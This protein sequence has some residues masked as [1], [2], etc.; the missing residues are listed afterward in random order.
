[1]ICQI[2]KKEVK[3]V[4]RHVFKSHN[5]LA[6]EYYDKYIANDTDGKCLVCGKKTKFLTINKGYNKYCSTK[7]SANSEV[8]KEN[9][10]KTMLKRYG[11]E[12]PMKSKEIKEKFIKT[13]NEKYGGN[14][15]FCSEKV[16]NKWRKNNIKK[17][18]VD[19]PFKTE[20]VKNKYKKTCLEK[21]GEEFP[22]KYRGK[23][24][25]KNL[26]NKYNDI[27]YNNHSKYEETCMRKYNVTHYSKTKKF[28]DER[29]KSQRDEFYHKIT[30]SDRLKDMVTPLFEIDSYN[31]C[32]ELYKFKCNKCGSIFKDTLKDGKIPRCL[33][34]YPITNGTSN[35]ESELKDYIK[36]IIPNEK[37]IF[38][39]RS[40]LE[41]KELD[42]YI[43]NKS[44]AIELNGNYWHSELS[45]NKS[46][47]YHL[48]K[49][50][51]CENL[52]IQLI[53]IFEDEW[54]F[55]K[56]IVKS[57]LKNIL[58]KNSKTI[59]ARKCN[60]KEINKEEAS[61]FLNG[62]H[63]QG[64]INSKIKLGI[65][66]KESLVSVMTLGKERIALGNKNIIDDNYEILRYATNEMVIGGFGKLLSYFIKNYKPNK[67]ITYA[68][69]RWSNGDIYKLNGFNKISDGVPNYWYMKNHS[70]RIHRF[71]FRKNV[72]N[73][74]LD[75]FDEN[76]TE[77]Q[78]MQLNGYDRIWDCG[79]L[80]YELKIN[81]EKNYGNN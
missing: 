72:L 13:N 76:L 19:V 42:I 79:S 33:V 80:K 12:H 14:S 54:M 60:V 62:I 64:Y 57:R 35:I 7:C 67:I 69:R 68:D 10:K 32:R 39:D 5:I 26:I 15:P 11:V 43:P 3:S 73:E 74:K 29:S 21:Y 8:V 38:N 65:F 22:W 56:E 48:N 47:N 66:Y 36:T 45:G 27:N 75:K 52:G 70:Q 16:R 63:I 40:L 6:Q 77:W 25:N 44:I 81:G 2:C 18:G 20:N 24:F 34:C 31:A 30:N 61:K 17:Y 4:G 53:H 23:M 59:F 28:R 78:N 55:K 58:L 9:F 71:N 50:I 51:E 37:F 41:R 1:M 49:T 46:K